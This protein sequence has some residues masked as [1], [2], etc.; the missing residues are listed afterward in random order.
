MKDIL[1]R[2]WA[3]AQLNMQLDITLNFAKQQKIFLVAFVL[4]PRQDW[5]YGHLLLPC[6]EPR[7]FRGKMAQE[8]E[9][10]AARLHPKKHWRANWT[11]LRKWLGKAMNKNSKI[12]AC[13]TH[14]IGVAVKFMCWP[15]L[16][17]HPSKI[18]HP[19]QTA[20]NAYASKRLWAGG[21]QPDPK[22][23][24]MATTLHWYLPQLGQLASCTRSQLGATKL[25]SSKWLRWVYVLRQSRIESTVPQ[26]S[27]LVTPSYL[28]AL[29]HGHFTTPA[30][31]LACL[32][33][34]RQHGTMAVKGRHQT[35]PC[36]STTCLDVNEIKNAYIFQRWN[37]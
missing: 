35:C 20:R 34:N 15:F 32:R 36:H 18:E 14:A 10:K 27:N 22:P 24:R 16:S 30:P 33:Q 37:I 13:I 9:L 23:K 1:R 12:T 31:K 28:F 17:F 7:F 19:Q 3:S 2:C 6:H 21:C 4:Q 26:F 5:R 8:T 25:W 29:C 11:R